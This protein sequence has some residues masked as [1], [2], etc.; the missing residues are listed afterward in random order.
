MS[1][2]T[3][4]P[5]SVLTSI[6]RAWFGGWFRAGERWVWAGFIWLRPVFP[7]HGRFCTWP[8]NATRTLMLCYTKV[9]SSVAFV[10]CVCA[11]CEF[12]VVLSGAFVV[13]VSSAIAPPHNPPPRRLAP[14]PGYCGWPLCGCLSPCGEVYKYKYKYSFIERWDMAIVYK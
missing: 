7:A 1:V 12:S 9:E 4:C 2:S 14:S 5:N 11:W 8:A 13:C 10:E 3:G 6:R